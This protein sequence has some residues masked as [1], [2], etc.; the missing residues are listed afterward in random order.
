MESIDIINVYKKHERSISNE[1]AALLTIAEM[2]SKIHNDLR[3][4]KSEYKRRP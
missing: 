4:L 2:L 3:E 1:V